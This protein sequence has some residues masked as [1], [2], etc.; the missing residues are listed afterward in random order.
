MIL[1]RGNVER[2]SEDPHTIEK[3]VSEGYKKMSPVEKTEVKTK[4]DISE[5]NTEELRVLAKEKGVE[6]CESLT[7]T[8]LL[9][10]LKDVVE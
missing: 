7:K 1:I 2:V 10:L 4:K 9:E 3:L 5:M 8:Q 6:G